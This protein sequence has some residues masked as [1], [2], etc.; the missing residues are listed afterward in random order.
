MEIGITRG[1]DEEAIAGRDPSSLSF[2]DTAPSTVG[3]QFVNNAAIQYCGTLKECTE[4]RALISQYP[5]RKQR[6]GHAAPGLAARR[7]GA[8]QLGHIDLR[9]PGP[10]Q[11]A[12]T[13]HERLGCSL[14]VPRHRQIEFLYGPEWVVRP[15]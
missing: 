3:R 13:G 15:V 1:F 14:D 4:G 9:S 6:P 12:P 8:L 5:W 11:M 10:D 7:R 2:V